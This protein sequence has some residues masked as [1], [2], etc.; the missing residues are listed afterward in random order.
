MRGEIVELASWEE[1]LAAEEA[2]PFA[3]LG[4]A[5]SLI[6]AVGEG[7]PLLLAASRLANNIH[8]LAR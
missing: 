3:D 7:V 5:E 2:D 6:P 1:V 8:V 4:D